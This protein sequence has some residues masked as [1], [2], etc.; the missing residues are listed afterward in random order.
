MDSVATTERVNCPDKRVQ[1]MF[2][3]PEKSQWM[4]NTNCSA[5]KPFVVGSNAPMI[6][7]FF[8]RLAPM[9][10]LCCCVFYG[11]NDPSFFCFFFGFFYRRLNSSQKV[12]KKRVLSS[13]F[14]PGF[15]LLISVQIKKVLAFFVLW[16]VGLREFRWAWCDDAV[17]NNTAEHFRVR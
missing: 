10:C 11:A 1:L 7:F 9:F 8:V 17:K 16:F 13:S 3:R 12:E 5:N 15:I 2:S 14:I 4:C 6:G